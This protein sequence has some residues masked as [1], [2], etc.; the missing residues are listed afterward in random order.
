VRV[1]VIDIGSNTARLLVADVDG[2][3]DAVREEKAY[4]G[5]GADAL[6]LGRLSDGKVAEAGAVTRRFS[7]I[8]RRLGADR[9]ETI[10][11]AP[12][13]QANAEALVDALARGGRGPVRVLSADEEGGLAFRGAVARE[14]GSLPGILAV[15]DVG[16]GSTEIAVGD[17]AHAADWVRSADLGSLRLTRACLPSDPPAAVEVRRARERVEDAFAGLTP[18]RPELA[19]AVGGSARAAAKVVGRELGPEELEAVVAICRQRRRGWIA[20]TFGVDAARAETLLAGALLLAEASR[21]LG[22][23]CRLAR[24][25]LREGAALAL[26][27]SATAGAAAA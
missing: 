25:G 5:L 18:P 9:L 11:T 7:R 3:V 21:A 12:G 24:G 4:L 26:A 1:G 17:P 16:G 19:L 6:Q 14:R 23:P 22:V 13:R 20:R 2:G 10:V 27:E 15:C 8:A